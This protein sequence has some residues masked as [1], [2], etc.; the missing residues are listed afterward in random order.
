MYFACLVFVDNAERAVGIV[1]IIAMITS[2]V[3]VDIVL[4]GLDLVLGFSVL[5]TCVSMT[6]GNALSHLVDAGDNLMGGV[7]IV[8]QVARI[9]FLFGLLF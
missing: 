5:N 8:T 7:L 1:Y 3:H 2:I 9:F 4:N 6:K